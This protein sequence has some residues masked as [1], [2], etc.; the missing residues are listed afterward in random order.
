MLIPST[1]PSLKLFLKGFSRPEL[2]RSSD[3]QTIK[4]SCPE[5]T[6]CFAKKYDLVPAE[7]YGVE[8]YW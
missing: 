2:H 3:K 1:I 8:K 6:S 4:T 5:L 7:P